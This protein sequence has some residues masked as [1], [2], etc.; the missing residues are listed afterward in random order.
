[1]DNTDVQNK[2]VIA[3]IIFSLVKVST[4]IYGADLVELGQNLVGWLLHLAIQMR[5]PWQ[6]AF[7]LIRVRRIGYLCRDPSPGTPSAANTSPLE[8]L[9]LC[10]Y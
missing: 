6:K 1:M 10:R 9:S 4:E 8:L 5:R 2:L 7:H 3:A